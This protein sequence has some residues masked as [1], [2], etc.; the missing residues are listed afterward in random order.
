[1]RHLGVGTVAFE[2]E[3]PVV[4]PDTGALGLGFGERVPGARGELVVYQAPALRI[5]N[6]G[7]REEH[8]AGVEAARIVAL[9]FRS[10]AEE[11][12]LEAERPVQPP[13]DVPP[14]GAAFRMRA[15]IAREL[16]RARSDSRVA[17]P[18]V[19]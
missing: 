17:N 14:L 5:R 11:G 3:R 16:Q 7:M 10:R 6:G 19:T 9:L 4:D 8:L 2:I 13:G 12:D 18:G 1:R 15:M